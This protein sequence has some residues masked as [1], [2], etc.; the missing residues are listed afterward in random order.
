MSHDSEPI[1]PLPSKATL[2]DVVAKINELIECI[3]HMWY[4]EDHEDE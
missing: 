1:Q 2:T 4:P 3:N